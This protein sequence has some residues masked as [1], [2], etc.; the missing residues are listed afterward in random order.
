MCGFS[1]FENVEFDGEFPIANI[2]FN[3]TKIT[4]EV[5]ITYEKS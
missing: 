4:K 2:S 3:E 1:H 5:K